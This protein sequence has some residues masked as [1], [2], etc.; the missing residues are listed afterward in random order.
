MIDLVGVS[1]GNL[2]SKVAAQLLGARETAPSNT[3]PALTDAAGDLAR[4]VAGVGPDLTFGTADDVDIDLV[5]DAYLPT[6]PHYGTQDAAAAVAFALSTGH[7]VLEARA[8]VTPDTVEV[9]EPA[10]FDATDSVIEPPDG[11]VT[12]RWDFGDGS[13]V[14]S[15]P[16]V[17]HAFAT[18]G[19]FTVTLTLADP[20]TDESDT[21]QVSVTVTPDTALEARASVTPDT[22]EVGEPASF[23]ATDSVIEPADRD[24]TYRWDFGDGSDVGSGRTVSHAFATAGD[25]TVTLTVADPDTDE[26]DTAQVSVTVTPDTALVERAHGTDRI[27]TAVA[28][29]QRGW[30]SSPRALL[31]TATNFPDALAAGALAGSLDAP[32]L[33]TDASTLSGAVEGELSRLAVKTVTILGGPSAVSEAVS[34]SLVDLGYTVERIEGP[35]RFATAAAV[36]K[37]VGAS[38]AKAVTI[39]LG[40]HADLTR[41]SW[42]DALSAGALSATPAR[43]PTLL[44]RSDQ[45]PQATRAALSELAPETV[46][47]L[48]GEA[49]VSEQVADQLSESG[50]VVERLEGDNRFETSVAVATKALEHLPDWTLEVVFATGFNYPD[51][52]AAGALA[53][54]RGALVM[55]VPRDALDQAEA[56]RDFLADNANR[57]DLG[58]VVGGEAAVSDAVRAGLEQAMAAT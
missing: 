50:Y 49:A 5:P 36:A 22:V 23:D 10:S 7:R 44:T 3:V 31:A 17:S 42:P 58:T 12:Y 54:R 32:L 18:T 4:T 55:L 24:V 30:T 41:Q 38:P 27:A 28:A 39:A 6:G 43:I 46:Y 48:G 34:S 56:V 14:G 8:S 45:L 20:D 25:F 53:A 57:L 19:D 1:V 52:L 47:V 11:N 37:R 13:D 29:S 15:G 16:T 40:Q 9:G 2:A 33:L 35:D 26:S 21:A 51:G